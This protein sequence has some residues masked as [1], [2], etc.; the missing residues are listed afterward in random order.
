MAG[1]A[2]KVIAVLLRWMVGG[3]FVYAGVLKALDPAQFAADVDNF[4]LLPYAMSCAV[5]VYLPWL[6]IF[7]GTALALGV[8]RAGA[9]F[10]LAAMLV[11]FLVALGS[12]WARGLD[13]T[14]GCFGHATNKTNYPLSLTM[15]LALLAALGVSVWRS[16]WR[17]SHG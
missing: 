2:E 9:A 16:D 3:V 4:R 12:A 7:A 5:G 14:C 8:W 6:E 1:H 15:D 13:I 17:K 10:V 11:A